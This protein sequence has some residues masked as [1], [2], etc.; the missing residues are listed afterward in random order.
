MDINPPAPACQGPPGC[1][2]YCSHLLV[3][4][5]FNY[6]NH[7]LTVVFSMHLHSFSVLQSAIGCL[8]VCY[9][10]LAVCYLLL[11]GLLYPTDKRVTP[12]LVY[13][14]NPGSPRKPVKNHQISSLPP[15]PLKI[16]KS[17]PRVTKSHQNVT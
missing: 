15:G 7:K 12:T 13:S 5:L 2:G 6:L 3:P 16:R 8:P 11:T 1:E 9:L 17:D 10:L 4:S 14:L